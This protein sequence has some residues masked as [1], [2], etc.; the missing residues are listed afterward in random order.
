MHICTVIRQTNTAET[1]ALCAH[2]NYKP[3]IFAHACSCIFIK[4]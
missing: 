4:F 2:Q 1:G 3:K